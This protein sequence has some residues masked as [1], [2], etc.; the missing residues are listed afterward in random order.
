MSDQEINTLGLHN[1]QY[2]QT[3]K[4]YSKSK[5]RLEA[6]SLSRTLQGVMGRWPSC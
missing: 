2:V 1:V 3:L 6:T 5:T 4:I